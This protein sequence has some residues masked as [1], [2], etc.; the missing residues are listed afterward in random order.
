MSG[1][2]ITR[3]EALRRLSWIA[4]AAVA[5]PACSAG[6]DSRARSPALRGLAGLLAHTRDA[7]IVGAA[8]LAERPEDADLDVLVERLGLALDSLPAPDSLELE[9]AAKAIHTRHIDDFRD[10][11]L[12][13][14]EGWNLSLTELSLAAV[15]HLAQ[16]A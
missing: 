5:G 9:V 4:A 3:R 2:S 6:N 15:A 8:F 12:I 1:A 13:E 16:L 10:G 7:A 14:I 11:R